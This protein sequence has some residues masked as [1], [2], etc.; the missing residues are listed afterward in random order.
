MFERNEMVSSVPSNRADPDLFYRK[1]AASTSSTPSFNHTNPSSTTSS[2]WRSR[3]RSTRSSGANGRIRRTSCYLRTVR[4]ALLIVASPLRLNLPPRR[5]DDKA[6]EGVRKAATGCLGEQPA[7]W[8]EVITR[9]H[10]ATTSEI[11][12]DDATR[13]HHCCCPP[14]SLLQRSRLSYPF[15]LCKLGPRDVHLRR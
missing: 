14:E 7:R 10:V 4:G 8:T 2:P 9:A 11:A 5:Q 1:R 12:P 6:M 15:N 13:Q 3:R